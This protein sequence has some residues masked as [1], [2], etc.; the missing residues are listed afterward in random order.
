MNGEILNNT[1]NALVPSANP[2]NT[3]AVT[4][5]LYI[6]SF[7]CSQCDGKRLSIVLPIMLNNVLRFSSNLAM[8]D[9]KEFLLS[10]I[11][12]L[13]INFFLKMPFLHFLK[14][15]DFGP[16]FYFIKKYLSVYSFVGKTLNFYFCFTSRTDM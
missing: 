15:S 16:L 3:R 5:N 13:Y 4:S 2:C 12:N 9:V 10:N 8:K 1:K 14:K 11:S 6:V 7:S